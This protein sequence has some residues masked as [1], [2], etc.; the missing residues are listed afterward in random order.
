MGQA[1]ALMVLAGRTLIQRVVDA[2]APL[3]DEI[4]LVTNAPDVYAHL[5]VKMVADVFAD[6]GS[7]GG[8]YSGL[9]AVT[10]EPAIAV[11]CDMPFLNTEL[12]RYLVSVSDGMDA[13]VP[14]LSIPSTATAVSST[15]AGQGRQAEGKRKA[16]QLDLHP[17]HA[18]Y[19]RAC[20]AP[21]ERQLRAGDLRM[22]G[23]F[24]DVRMRYVKRDEVLRFDLQLYSFF[25]A[26]TPD[27]LAQAEQ[28]AHERGEGG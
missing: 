10:H 16:K 1:K 25:N 14:D 28:I 2:L 17:L 22:M 11:A 27:E 3:C 12:L 20:L 6:T 8:L 19:R 21:I 26:N 7:L 13:A 15:S 4:V 24:D 23:F 5:G 9:S 18:V